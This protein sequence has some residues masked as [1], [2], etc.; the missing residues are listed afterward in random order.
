MTCLTNEQDCFSEDGV[1][2]PFQTK[3]KL[4]VH[5]LKAQKTMM[6]ISLS[7]LPNAADKKYP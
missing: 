4:F 5:C 2:F 7:L 3:V 1:V 6:Q